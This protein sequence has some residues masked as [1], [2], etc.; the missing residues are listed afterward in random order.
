MSD[1][2]RFDRA[3]VARA[4]T[5]PAA[6]TRPDPGTFET[7]GASFRVVRDEQEENQLVRIQRATSDLALELAKSDPQ[8][9]NLS[10]FL[11]PADSNLRR[12]G[13]QFDPD[14]VW[15]EIARRRAA[16]PVA[17]KELGTREEFEQ[18]LLRRGDGRDRDLDTVERGG[19]VAGFAGAV[20]GEFTDPINLATLPIG[21][22]G[23]T[24]F[25]KIL[26]EGLIN[27]GI[28]AAQT[29]G[30][31]RARTALGEELTTRE[32]L[33]NI[34]TAG[35]GGAIIRGGI[36][37]APAVGR[38][39]ARTARA[40]D[41]RALELAKPIREAIDGTLGD[42]ELAR[43]F[44]EMVPEHA[45]TPEQAAALQVLQRTLDVEDASPFRRTITADDVHTARL[46]DELARLQQGQIAPEAPPPLARPAAAGGSSSFDMGNFMARN[47][48]AES[49]GNDAAQAATSSAFGRYQFLRDTWLEFYSRT[50]GDTG[51]GKAAILAKR[52]DGSVQDKVMETFTRANIRAL[53]RAGVPVRDNTVYLAHF[54]G[55]KDAI[56]VMRNAPDTPITQVVS[57]AAIEANPAVFNSI[58]NAGDLADWAARKMAGG[59]GAVPVARSSNDAT[60]AALDAQEAAL[61]VERAALEEVLPQSRASLVPELDRQQF[62][63]DSAWRITQAE[64]AARV[65][66][67]NPA[68][69][70]LYRLRRVAL[71]RESGLSLNRTRELARELGMSEAQ[72]RDG[73]NRLRDLG[74]LRQ[75]ARGHFS[76][77]PRSSGREEDVLLFIARRGGIAQDG[78]GDGARR[79]GSRGHDLRN[80]GALDRFVPGGGPLLRAKGRALDDIG[81]D[82]WEEGFFGPPDTTPRPDEQAV[83]DLLERATSGKERI[84]AGGR[85]IAAKAAREPGSVPAGFRDRGEFEAELARHNRAAQQAL[86][87]DLTED[88]FLEI[89]DAR[90]PDLPE[91]EPEFITE[92][93]WESGDLLVPRIMAWVNRQLDEVLEDAFYEAED[94]IYAEIAREFTE[95]AARQTDGGAARGARQAV[96]PGDAGEGAA[97]SGSGQGNDRPPQL[98]PREQDAAQAEGLFGPPVDDAARARAFDADDGEGVRAIAESDWHDIRAA[99][100]A[101]LRAQA[102]LRGENVTGQA[103]DGTMGLG[104]FDSADQP[105]FDLEDGLGPRTAAEIDEAIQA[106]RAAIE[107]IRRCLK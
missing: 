26:G 74:E 98:N 32:A 92:S 25:I 2:H 106:D 68:D 33:I 7:V 18:R 86:G 62:D 105:K 96:E 23:K 47:R 50:F 46:S 14:A 80:T 82:L 84:F 59:D 53:D 91:I 83:L 29:P 48:V 19:G 13:F 34:G 1:H 31:A 77:L 69:D 22:P 79:G 97:R 57:R 55:T 103:Q 76:R 100:Q 81:E 15:R 4:Q 72:L 17:F 3:A 24:I 70:P 52:A 5:A 60:A 35:A 8:K 102:P 78:L 38:T 99:Q 28:E 45:R 20:G 49:S 107:E 67:E 66:G 21:G 39:T 56:A 54:L 58:R 9:R 30:R 41:Q 89:L 93:L 36:E 61:N 87:R 44:A 42:R 63:S 37:I 10:P 75:N 64:Q 88:E 90:L 85:T 11:L 40:I 43:A 27:A 51:E 6:D 65:L 73:L 104:L 95:T 94:E 12:A 101:A 16:D 71:D